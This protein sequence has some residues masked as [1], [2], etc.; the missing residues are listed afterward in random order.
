M[1]PIFPRSQS[2]P[3]QPADPAEETVT[4]E[5]PAPP[6]ATGTLLHDH[7]RRSDNDAFVGRFAR[8][9]GGEH[10]GRYGVVDSISE[11][12]ADGL[13]KTAVFRTRDAND[14]RLEVAY[15]HLRPAEAGGR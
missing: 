14:E 5:S 3:E 4:Q 9:V 10:E 7:N 11:F 12:G 6:R 13:P 2:K 15:E 8:V 1:A